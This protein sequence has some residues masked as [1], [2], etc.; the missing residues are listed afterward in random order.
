MM[1]PKRKTDREIFHYVE[2]GGDASFFYDGP[3]TN[4]VYVVFSGRS[5]Y[6]FQEW[7]TR[8]AARVNGYLLDGHSV[9]NIKITAVFDD[10]TSKV[11]IRCDIL[12]ENKDF[13]Y[14]I[15]NENELFYYIKHNDKWSVCNSE[16]IQSLI[17]EIEKEL[18][19]FLIRED[20]SV[21]PLE[22]ICDDK[23]DKE[24]EPV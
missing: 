23:L 16:K 13:K 12:S 14:L 15:T 1:K 10:K 20:C 19:V 5:T 4:R 9:K 11:S 7:M 21:T 8:V 6:S 2:K 3:R 17:E 24:K 22:E 18:S